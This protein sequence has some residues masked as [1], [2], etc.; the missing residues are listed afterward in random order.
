MLHSLDESVGEIVS[1]LSR[2][3]L[4]EDTIIAFMSDNGGPTAI[5]DIHP[6]GASNY[7]LRGVSEFLIFEKGKNISKYTFKTLKHSS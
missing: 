4:I 7:P 3:G 1:A 6:T 5:E 2:N